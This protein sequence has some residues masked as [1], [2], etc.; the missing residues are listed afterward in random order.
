MVEHMAEVCFDKDGT[1][2]DDFDYL[3]RKR[4]LPETRPQKC[5]SACMHEQFEIVSNFS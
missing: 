3:F 5:L 1:T 2:K 4:N